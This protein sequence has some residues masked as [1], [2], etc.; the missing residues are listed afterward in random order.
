MTGVG[1]AYL[2]ELAASLTLVMAGALR[3]KLRQPERQ[4]ALER[5]ALAG[6]HALAK[7]L[8]LPGPEGENHAKSLLEWLVRGDRA[9]GDFSREVVGLLG[10]KALEAQTLREILAEAGFEWDHFPSVD[11]EAAVRAFEA[12]YV[13]AAAAEKE[14]QGEIQVE[15]LRQQTRL[16]AEILAETKKRTTP[17][18]ATTSAARRQYLEALRRECRDLHL[19]DLG[20]RGGLGGEEITLDRVFI[21]LD[22]QTRVV[23]E[24]EAGIAEIH[25]MPFFGG[26]ESPLPALGAARRA[27]RLV[28][29]GDPGSGKSSFVK[30]LCFRLA[31]HQLTGGPGPFESAAD[32]LLPVYLECRP[33]ARALAGLDLEGKG[34]ADRRRALAE[35][36]GQVLNEQLATIYKV[37]SFAGELDATLAVGRCLLVLDGLDEVPVDLRS[38]VREAVSALL[39]NTLERVI[40]TYRIRS[41]EGEAVLAGF[42][43]HTLA[44]LDEV[45]IRH[46]VQAWYVALH[47]LGRLRADQDWEALAKDLEQAALARALGG[48]ASNPMLLTTMALLHQEGAKLPPERARLFQQALEVL[49]LKWKGGDQRRAALSPELRALLGK[50][51]ELWQVLQRLGFEVHAAEA[52]AGGRG[53]RESGTLGWAEAVDLLAKPELLKSRELAIEFLAYVDQSAGVL[54]GQGGPPGQPAAYGFPHRFF[55]EYLAGRYLFRVDETADAIRARAAEGDFWQQAVALGAEDYLY[56]NTSPGGVLARAICLC[57]P[58]ASVPAAQRDRAAL[59]AGSMAVLVAESASQKGQPTLAGLT[60]RLVEVLTGNALPARQRVEAGRVLGRLGDP[61]ESVKTAAGMEF[62]WVPAGPF[63]MGANESDQGASDYERPAGTYDVRGGYWIGRYPVTQGQYTEYLEAASRQGESL[64]D[65]KQGSPIPFNLP[66][67]PVAA[68]DWAEAVTYCRWLTEKARVE[69]WIPSA[70]GFSLPSEPEWEKAA[71]GGAMLPEPEQP[72][73]LSKGVHSLGPPACRPN[74]DPQR[75]YPFLGEFDQEKVNCV[76]AIGTPNAAGAY[77]AGGSPYGCEELSGGVW[78]WTRS[79]WQK[80]YPYPTEKAEVQQREDLAVEARWK[81]VLRGGS[82][83]FVRQSVRCSARHKDFPLSRNGNFGF[84]V[85]LLPYFSDL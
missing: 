18:P 23:V 74:E 54:V 68:V 61:R 32:G 21:A 60:Q 22:T 25:L 64:R 4:K 37:P 26:R 67:H 3:K 10:D 2:A 30:E 29:L 7:R 27:K 12:A 69:D 16:L 45:R 33:L 43:P 81:R 63:F 28:L 17:P 65:P 66:N 76:S 11:F 75:V 41:Y 36:V 9:G 85:V 70:W 56:C 35:T 49:A 73:S 34:G 72:R 58:D 47:E 19:V 71:R 52:A 53:A 14:L 84:R 82:F 6:L 80:E 5:A 31:N 59:W 8:E 15:H 38:T 77:A 46:F 44:E 55:Q 20:G 39:G 62:C 57:Q 40:V 42:E 51:L 48:L 13:Q 1:E 50:N 79:V 78:E 24:I 83:A